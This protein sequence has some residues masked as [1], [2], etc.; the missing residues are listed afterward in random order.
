VAQVRT[1]RPARRGTGDGGNHE[2]IGT[3]GAKS[4]ANWCKVAAPWT[5]WNHEALH[6]N[7]Y[8]KREG[9]LRGLYIYIYESL[10]TILH[11]RLHQKNCLNLLTFSLTIGT[12]VQSGL[13][14]EDRMVPR[15]SR[16]FVL[17][18]GGSDQASF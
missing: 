7:L 5:Q 11:H 4:G 15:L 9:F 3:I 13:H 17:D 10:C 1:R 12:L 16:H 6:Q 14:P 2:K 8:R 18:S